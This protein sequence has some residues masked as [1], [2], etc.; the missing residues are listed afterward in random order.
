MV[1]KKQLAAL[2]YGRAIRKANI[3]KGIKRCKTSKKKTKV[4][5]ED[6]RYVIP[7]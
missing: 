5:F 7:S 1:T 3:R 2:A 6:T 4:S